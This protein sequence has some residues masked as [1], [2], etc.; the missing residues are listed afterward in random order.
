MTY[1]PE[2]TA[3]KVSGD[4]D[5]IIIGG[6]LAGLT[7]AVHLGQH[8]VKVL[9]LEK[10]SYPHHKVCGEYI[11]NEVLPY[12]QSLGIQPVAHGAVKISKFKITHQNGTCISTNLPLGGFGMSRHALDLLL[13]NKAKKNA[14]MLQET[15]TGINYKESANNQNSVFEV[16]TQS[17]KTFSAPYVVAAYGKRS[18]IDKTLN[19]NFIQHKTP[20]MAVKAHYDFEMPKNEVL[21]HTFNGGYCGISKTETGAVNACYLAKTTYFKKYKDIDDFQAK[22]LSQNAHLKDFFKTAMPLFKK[23]LTI[24][25]ISF[26]E[27]EPVFNHIFMLGDTAG[28]IHPLCG[29]GMAMAIHSAK[30]F[31]EL[32]LDFKKFNNP[33]RAHLEKQY[34]ILWK[35]TFASRLNTGNNLQKLLLNDT[36]SGIGFKTARLF[37]FIIPSIVKKTH[38][39]PLI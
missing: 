11:S 34:K 4:Y 26:E 35:K 12:L 25:Q 13:Y 23:P 16:S 10:Q 27:K 36:L 19:R 3:M 39:S 33:Q 30:I 22:H 5:V 20:W 14:S 21:L 31:S 15:V 38:G 24:S 37:P 32:F 28:L 29:N 1:I 8:N 2:I 6:G 9:V 18:T 17:G 7:T